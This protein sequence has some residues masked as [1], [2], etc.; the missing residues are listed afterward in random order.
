MNILYLTVGIFDKGGISRYNRFQIRALRELVGAERV[1]VL[2]LLGPAGSP[3][4]LETPFA[5]DWHG[6]RPQ[7]GPAERAAFLGAVLRWSRARRPDVIWCAHLHYVAFA[8]LLARASGARSV[9]QVYG[10]EVWTPRLYRPDVGWGFAHC[11]HVLSDCHFTAE[12]AAC[13]FPLQ[14]RVEVIWDCVDTQRFSPGAPA[15]EV[16][17]RYG[18]PDP[19]RHFNVLTLG[20]MSAD[21]AFKGYVRLLEVLPHLPP[22]TR[23]IY[24]GGGDL[25][26]RLRER[27]RE[28]GVAER[29]VLT[30]FVH[31]ADLADVYRSA[32]VLS[33]V[34]NREPGGGEG[35]PLTPLEAAACGVP[36]L[37]GNQDGSRE[38]VEQGVNGLALDPF[39]LPEL[40]R[41]LT[42]LHDDEPLRRRMGQAARARVEREHDYA[43]FRERTGRFVAELG[44]EPA[45][46]RRTQEETPWT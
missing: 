30:G 19:A 24:G 40:A 33:L 18:L 11:D 39:D 14:N 7:A 29:V 26:P 36:I 20:R 38:A 4:D 45:A 16:L 2:S 46:G 32:A 37:V 10:A 35:I 13:H 22:D 42:R 1:T 6:A 31:E 44:L 25:I 3:R 41:R 27:A 34:G 8:W 9:V 43:V 21:A 5:V 17:A 15:P 28:L 23:L 12:Y